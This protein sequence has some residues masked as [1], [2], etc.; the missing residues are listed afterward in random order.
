MKKTVEY[1][2]TKGLHILVDGAAA[3][4]FLVCFLYAGYALWDTYCVLREP[5]ALKAE[6]VEYRPES[7]EEL[8]Y[9]FQQLL[10]M[11]PDVCAWLT[12]DNTNI[13]YPVV[14]GKDNF[15]YL[16]MDI[17]GEEAT[18]G[19][20]F[21]D[22]QN[23]REFRDFYSI[24]MGHHMQGGKM[25]GD[26]GLFVDE[27]FFQKNHTGTIYLPDRIFEL[28]IVAILSA[29][30]YDQTLYRIKWDTAEE[31]EQLLA[32]IMETALFTRGEPLAPEDQLLA[33][34][35]CSSSYTNARYLLICRIVVKGSEEL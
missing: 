15:E 3:L 11:N 25:F 21:L 14:Q 35:T 6:L 12:I 13:D 17:L 28:E 10:S 27:D 26:V 8:E 19:S 29:D 2:M 4:F 31:K 24:L 22:Y 33:L 16:N 7:I 5:E 18:A 32:H 34:S 30:A 20:I 1:Y 9:S 23:N